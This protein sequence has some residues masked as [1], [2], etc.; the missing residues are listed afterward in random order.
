MIDQYLHTIEKNGTLL[1][2]Y[3]EG[4][5]AAAAKAY[6][7]G[8][9]RIVR[10]TSGTGSWKIGASEFA[11]GE[12]DLLLFNNV[13]PR[14]ITAVYGS[15]LKFEVFGFSVAA[16]SCEPELFELFYGQTGEG[17]TVFSLETKGLEEIHCILDIL[18]RKLKSADPSALAS[19]NLLRAA[20]A[21]LAELRRNAKDPKA[22]QRIPAYTVCETVSK[23]I[24][25]IE[26]NLSRI[27]D[28][29]EVA[30][31]LHVSRTYLYKIFKQYTGYTPKSYITQCR[32]VRFLRLVT[33]RDITVL[34]AA[35]NCG[36]ESASGFYKSFHAVCGMSPSA[37]L[38]ESGDNGN[39]EAADV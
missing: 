35:M 37:Y 13:T 9:L 2:G 27:H 39:G 32:I 1:V 20:C 36:F 17:K 10:I 12:G 3:C 26:Q 21:M 23:A 6:L 4:K 16:V 15:P 31:Y 38:S 7:F 22:A 30:E 28:V 14:Q 18:K 29:S 19:V 33:T 11:V 8:G 24:G 34:D 25:Y 5:A